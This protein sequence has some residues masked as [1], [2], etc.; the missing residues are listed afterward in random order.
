MK[1]KQLLLCITCLTIS[2]GIW[3]QTGAVN[4]HHEVALEKL[5]YKEKNTSAYSDNDAIV[6]AGYRIQVFSSNAAKKA[7]ENAFLLRKK[8]RNDY[9]E[10]HVYVEY[11]APFWKVRLG[12][13]TQYTDAV[14]CSQQLKE[15]YP[16]QAGEVII[17]K[18]KK[19]KPIYFGETPDYDSDL[20]FEDE[21]ISEVEEA[22]VIE[23]T[24]VAE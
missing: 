5:L 11:Q 3:A 19:I 15:A 21:F 2:T 13:F 1:G 24:A 12:D 7:K 4:T 17:V 23:E 14:I 18:E 8:L 10:H 6:A 20:S 9:P 16:K 22:E